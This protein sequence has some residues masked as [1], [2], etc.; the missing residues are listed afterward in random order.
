MAIWAME[1]AIESHH[2]V[3]YGSTF[4]LSLKRA[5]R[6]HVANFWRRQ[7]NGFLSNAWHPPK[8][9]EVDPCVM[10]RYL[11]QKIGN[12]FDAQLRFAVFGPVIVSNVFLGEGFHTC[13]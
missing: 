2:S 5:A 4:V 9:W 7:K 8:R 1:I 12:T 6:G 13:G 10:S 11:P 3:G